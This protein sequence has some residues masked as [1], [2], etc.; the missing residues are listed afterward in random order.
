M[1]NRLATFVRGSGLRY[2]RDKCL[3]IPREGEAA[4]RGPSHLKLSAG[5]ATHSLSSCFGTNWNDR[6]TALAVSVLESARCGADRVSSCLAS[7]R[8]GLSL[9]HSIR[10]SHCI[11]RVEL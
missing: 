3:A 11:G 4:R 10:R 6:K 5:Q 9:S 7:Q 1:G 2:D 8:A